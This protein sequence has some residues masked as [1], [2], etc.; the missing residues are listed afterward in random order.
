M[1]PVEIRTVGL[2]DPLAGLVLA[3]L[4]VEYEARYGETDELSYA[5]A[6]EFEAPTGA[7][8]VLVVGDEV[9]AGGGVRAHG[10][11]GIA[12]V[13]RMWTHPDHRRRGHASTVL[14]ALEEVARN[15][16]YTAVRLETGPAQPEAQ[17]MYA[18]RGYRRI[19][20]Y[21]RYP[22]ALAYERPC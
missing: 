17:A 8:V 14:T 19:P 6:E 7:F 5:H 1:P 4:A 13:K 22:E 16:G 12:E 15:A 10:D 21:G 2:D 3:G 11:P 9:V 18:A 20:V